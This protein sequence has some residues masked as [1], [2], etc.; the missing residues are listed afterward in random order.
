MGHLTQSVIKIPVG[1][2]LSN[3]PTI[4]VKHIAYIRQKDFFIQSNDVSGGI[5]WQVMKGNT[6]ERAI[7]IR[8]KHVQLSKN[9]SVIHN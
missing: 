2:R 1:Q 8:V 4:N 9:V 5:Y 3:M 7:W 6:L